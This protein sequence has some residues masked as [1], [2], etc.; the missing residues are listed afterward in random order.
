MDA[1]QTGTP[2]Q[3]IPQYQ[4]S[5]K[6]LWALWDIPAKVTSVAL[7]PLTYLASSFSNYENNKKLPPCATGHILWG[8]WPELCA[9][10]RDLMQ[11]IISYSNKYGEED[12]ICKLKIGYKTFYIVKNPEMAKEI[13]NDSESY[14]R[15]ESLS[16]WQKFS[17]GGLS[18][19]DDTKRYRL[20]AL[21]FIG[22]QKKLAEFFPGKMKIAEKWNVR[23]ADKTTFDLFHEA[24]RVTLAAMG[25]TFFHPVCGE[26]PFGL[27]PSNDQDSDKFL[28]A[29]SKLFQIMTNRYTSLINSIPYVGDSLYSVLYSE[30]DEIMEDCKDIL[31]DILKPIFR[32]I[33]ENPESEQAQKVCKDFGLDP[34]NIN[35]DEILD[36]S[37]GFSGIF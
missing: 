15:G 8:S 34:Q 18:E 30:E 29:Y 22:G 4:E 13:L 9:M 12:G 10:D 1:V 35:L 21:N 2:F 14:Q 3:R 6:P 19:G 32:K 33:F 31:K 11:M 26:N 37:L 20:L 25:E 27:D 17:K 23:L 5:F 36:K 16:I 28:E 7:T 24:E